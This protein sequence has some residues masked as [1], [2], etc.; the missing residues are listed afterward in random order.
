MSS[1]NSRISDLLRDYGLGNRVIG[2]DEMYSQID[3]AEV[4]AYIMRRR[5]ESEKFIKELLG[6]F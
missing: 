1:L 3:Y 4:N 6:F 5:T 2:Y